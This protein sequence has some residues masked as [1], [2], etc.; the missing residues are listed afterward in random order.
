ML[1]HSA[2]T[3]FTTTGNGH[4]Q[5]CRC[6]TCFSVHFPLFYFF[7]CK[8]EPKILELLWGGCSS[9]DRADPIPGGPIPVYF[10]LHAKETNPKLLC[11][12]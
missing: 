12:C 6:Y 11:E 5:H 2:L 3:C 10:S 1:L 4:L 8:Q 9:G 7:A